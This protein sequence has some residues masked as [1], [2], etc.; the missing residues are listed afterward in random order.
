MEL[1]HP[2]P[3]ARTA[4]RPQPDLS[5]PPTPSSPFPSRPPSPTSRVSYAYPATE[6]PTPSIAQT[7]APASRSAS[8]SKNPL[9]K[10]RR[11]SQRKGVAGWFGRLL[12]GG[13]GDQKQ[14][15][16]EMEDRGRRRLS[17]G[18]VEA[19]LDANRKEELRRAE[20][21]SKASV[22]SRE[23]IPW[24]KMTRQRAQLAVSFGMV[25]LV[26]MNDSATGANL[27]SMQDHYRVSY[28]E[29]SL[30]FLANTAGYFAS[31]MSAS[32]VLHHWGLQ[33]SLAVACLGMCI[34][35]IILSVAPPFPV[36]V[37]ALA[38]MGFGGG[39]YDACITTV[40]SHEEDGILMSLLY[41]CFGIGATFS[42]LIIGAFVD[43]GYDWNRYYFMPLGI[44]LI[45]AVIGFFVFRGYETPP[46]ETHDA[47]M[48]TAQ[49]PEAAAAGQ[50]GQVI[51]ARAVMSAQER[52]KRAL[53]IRAVWVGF[54]L[55]ILA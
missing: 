20:Q 25:A 16:V 21:G 51:H 29:I 43:K 1:P 10:R 31:S 26:G 46:D 45:L 13:K 17:V 32:F 15:N 44:A 18:Q 52:M 34:G 7:S 48:S 47:P 55:I 33:V 22:T 27:D 41:S 4:T 54:L 37:C 39:M 24:Y 2:P 35:C 38:F 12:D 28:D 49:A 42:P 14:E 30:V 6:P 19:A 9:L 36:F 50:E 8:H 23:K 3:A 40:V 53:R 11:S 5:S